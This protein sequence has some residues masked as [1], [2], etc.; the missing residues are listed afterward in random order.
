MGIIAFCPNGHRTKVKDELA[1]KKGICPTCGSRFRIPLPRSG[2]APVAAASPPTARLV[3]LDP[4][5]ARSLPVAIGLHETAAGDAMQP[6]A[7][8][9]A[10][11]ND[12]DVLPAGAGTVEAAPAE[13]EF[14][15]L[16]EHPGLAWCVA[17]RG[18]SPSPPMDATA[19]RMWLASGAATADHVVWRQDWAE[20]RPV[21]E[22]FP[23]ALPAP[24]P[25][26]P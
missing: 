26:W 2:D 19:M 12:S 18:G 17:E 4:R 20:W 10:I 25:R 23:G 1:G 5:V 16:D 13:A 21:Q 24:S 8:A 3:S 11:D 9:E 15:A 14:A 7:T 6:L 22:L